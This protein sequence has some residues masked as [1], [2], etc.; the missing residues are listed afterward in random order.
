[1][2]YLES[3]NFRLLKPKMRPIR[4]ECLSIKNLLN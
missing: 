1:M 3:S 2:P 4:P